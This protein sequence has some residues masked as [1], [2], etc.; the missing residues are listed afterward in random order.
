MVK[1]RD[2]LLVLQMG[3]AVFILDTI[4]PFLRC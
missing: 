3:S 1:G 4:I 2:G